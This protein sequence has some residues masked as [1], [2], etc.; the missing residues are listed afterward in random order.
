[1]WLNTIV[2]YYTTLNDS[3]SW[4]ATSAGE[5]QCN[6]TFRPLEAREHI[7]GQVVKIYIRR[8]RDTRKFWI[9]S[10]QRHAASGG[11]YNQLNSE[12]CNWQLWTC[13][14]NV[15]SRILGEIH[16][17][18]FLMV[19]INS[20]IWTLNLDVLMWSCAHAFLVSG[21]PKTEKSVCHGHAGT[22]APTT[23]I[24]FCDKHV[25]CYLY[26]CSHLRGVSLGIP[27]RPWILW[28]ARTGELVYCVCINTL[29]VVHSH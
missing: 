19:A 25:V 3:W 7:S 28:H 5:G 13:M 17:Q 26:F 2:Q 20:H 1:M 12:K 10:F 15:K 6:C 29:P 16:L 21:S 4:T 11:F 23:L 24:L 27:T 18:L 8:S 9:S 22:V 14:K